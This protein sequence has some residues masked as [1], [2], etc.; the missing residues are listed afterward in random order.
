MIDD[1]DLAGALPEKRH[2]RL[3][4]EMRRRLDGHLERCAECR[5]LER[6]SAELGDGLESDVA[7]WLDHPQAQLLAAW[8]SD[9]DGVPRKT[10]E[11]IAGHVFSCDACGETVRVLRQ[12]QLDP[13]VRFLDRDADL[14][15]AASPAGGGE[16]E[17]VPSPVRRIWDGLASTV[18]RPVPA[19][20]YLVL[21][22]VVWI[23]PWRS[24]PP[25]GPGAGPAVLPP[26]WRIAPIDT[27][28]SG[29]AAGEPRIPE[30]E[31][32][33]S[34]PIHL[35]LLTDLDA[36]DL[37]RPGVVMSAEIRRDGE[38]VWSAEV[39]PGLV[40]AYGQI[41]LLVPASGLDRDVPLEIRVMSS[42]D[43][44]TDEVFRARV[45]L[46]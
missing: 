18:L 30:I 24:E 38:V 36:F 42:R 39:P 28:R 5:E 26:A 32:L 37:E 20:A 45:R 3:D 16:R 23:A 9:P 4:P 44:E 31:A 33:P 41:D 43:G 21:L 40:S 11:W 27:F 25:P 17:R 12:L 35:Q 34:A 14:A 6:L 8:A 19:L 46:R 22:A 2:G 1:H 15:E 29:D 10:G 7:E 13:E